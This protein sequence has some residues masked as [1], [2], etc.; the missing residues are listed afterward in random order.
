VSLIEGVGLGLHL[1]LTAAGLITLLVGAVGVMN[2]MLV[3]VHERRREVGLRKAVGASERAIFVQFLAE[4]LAITGAAGLAGGALGW[5]A[6][7]FLTAISPTDSAMVFTPQLDAST[8][9]FV[10]LALMGVGVVAGVVPAQRAARI[11]P[12]ISMRSL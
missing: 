6:V 11:D 3:V 9:V 8:V 12:A 2:I 10:A 4:A 7:R 1:F 5:L